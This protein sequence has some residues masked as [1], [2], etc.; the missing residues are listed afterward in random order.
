MQMQKTSE[1]QEFIAVVHGIKRPE[2]EIALVP[3]KV[4]KAKLSDILG[5]LS[6]ADRS[7]NDKAGF[8][9]FIS[10]LKIGSAE[11]GIL[12]RP[13]N[14]AVA[15]ASSISALMGCA[16][17]IYRGNFSAARQYDG[18]A[19]HLIKLCEGVTDKF[20][21]IEM[22][23]LNSQPISVDGFF[24][25]QVERFCAEVDHPDAAPSFFRGQA[26]ESAEGELK[27][28]DFRGKMRRGILVV[29]GSLKEISCV[30][31]RTLTD[32]DILN[33]TNKRTWV[34]GNAIY[35]GESA[36]PSRI[37]VTHMRPIKAQ[38]DPSTWKGALNHFEVGDWGTDFES[39]N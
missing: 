29:S 22:S 8:E 24:K 6:A 14:P 33:H 23:S 7:A 39:F 26:F 2:D 4:F 9:Y 36:L 13:K 30:F 16:D 1:K 18:V 5:A 38:G 17:A 20:E 34:E 35:S 27:E 19:K 3:A 25:G 15:R 28:V 10:R 31:T 37:E 11:I 12:E 21:Y 32:D